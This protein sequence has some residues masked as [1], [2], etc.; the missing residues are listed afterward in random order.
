MKRAFEEWIY[1]LTMR[2]D[3]IADIVSRIWFHWYCPYPIH[4]N[5]RASY[6]VGRGDCGC[7]NK[8]RYS[9]P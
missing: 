3:W 7:S 6:C 4:K 2:G 8:R 9:K 1:G 5:Y